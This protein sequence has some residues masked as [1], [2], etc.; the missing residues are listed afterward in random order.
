MGVTLRE[1]E[2]EC[3]RYTAEDKDIGFTEDK[4]VEFKSKDVYKD[5]I[6][7]VLGSINRAVQRI[8]SQNKI[9]HK[10][11]VL[12]GKKQQYTKNEIE[13][14]IKPLKI[15]DIYSVSIMTSRGFVESIDFTYFNNTLYLKDN[16]YSKFDVVIDF[17]PF[18]KKLT[19]EDEENQLIENWETSD[20]SI[21]LEE[22]GLPYELLYSVIIY[23]VKGELFGFDNPSLALK[24]TQFAEQYLDEYSILDSVFGK[25]NE[26]RA[27]A[28]IEEF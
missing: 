2:T 26:V 27:T 16:R 4:Y 14:L 9:P 15:R 20:T 21:D 18:I 23:F 24:Y 3:I 6:N 1:F 19:K 11:L 25:Q 12:K 28:S 17:I 8:A 7:N 22:V 5:Y 13:E 10:Q